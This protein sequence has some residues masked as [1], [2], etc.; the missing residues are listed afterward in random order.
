MKAR[1]PFD[2]LTISSEKAELYFKELLELV[3][4]RSGLF[5]KPPAPKSQ[6]N[7]PGRMPHVSPG[8]ATED[9]ECNPCN[10]Y[11]NSR[12]YDPATRNAEQKHEHLDG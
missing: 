4:G 3:G 5:S 7:A 11:Q 6:G 10:P 1:L 12:K 9:F 8:I 2:P